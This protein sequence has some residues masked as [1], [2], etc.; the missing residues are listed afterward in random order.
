MVSEIHVG[1][2]NT[3]FI[4]DLPKNKPNFA[5]VCANQVAQWTHADVTYLNCKWKS[6]S[7]SDRIPGAQE[8][9]PAEQQYQCQAPPRFYRS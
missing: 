2:W 4:T 9:R 8:T 5:Q 6:P 7:L 1:T 3:A